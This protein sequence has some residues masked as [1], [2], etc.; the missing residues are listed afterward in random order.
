MLHELLLALLGYTSDLNID[1]RDHRKSF[2][3]SSDSSISEE[4]NFT[5]APDLSILQPCEQ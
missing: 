4:C 5:V 1:E 3:L 2:G